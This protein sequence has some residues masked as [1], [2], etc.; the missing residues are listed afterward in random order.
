M[1][2]PSILKS[3]ARKVAPETPRAGILVIT[4]DDRFFY[5]LFAVSLDMGWTIRRAR[6]FESA[7]KGLRSQPVPVVI[8]DERLPQV[9]WRDALRTFSAFPGAPRCC[10]PSLK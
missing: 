6:T 10:S 9:D 8:Y 7:W 3:A 1:W 5:S 2:I 4:P